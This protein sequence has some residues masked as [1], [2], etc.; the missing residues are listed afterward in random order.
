MSIHVNFSNPWPG[1]LDRKHTPYMEKPQSS[2]PNQLNIEGL[3]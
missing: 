1:A 2:I 3:T